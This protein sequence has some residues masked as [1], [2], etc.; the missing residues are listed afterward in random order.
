MAL[1]K[2]T[3]SIKIDHYYKNIIP[4]C[5]NGLAFDVDILTTHVLPIICWYSITEKAKI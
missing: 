1:L 2:V 5:P 3:A 4:G